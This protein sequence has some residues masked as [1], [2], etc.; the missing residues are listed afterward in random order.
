MER[1]GKLRREVRR[2]I[3]NHP[4]VTSYEAANENEGGEGV[5]IAHL[6]TVWIKARYIKEPG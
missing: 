5:T 4:L 2:H 1:T 3:S 6:V